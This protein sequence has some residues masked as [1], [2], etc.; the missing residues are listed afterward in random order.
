[1]TSLSARHRPDPRRAIRYCCLLTTAALAPATLWAQDSTGAALLAP[2]P[3]VDPAWVEQTVE[4]WFAETVR[5]TRGE[6]G[7][8]IADQSG[9]LLWGQNPD[10]P[11]VPASTLKVFTTGFARSVLG[12]NARR[13]TRV[14][15][16]G[17]VD[18]VSGQWLGSWGLELNGDPS[19]DVA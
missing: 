2:A 19:L 3:A 11:M 8:A 13:P 9:R 1:M 14:I 7:I 18:P 10:T 6:W 4:P 16:T 12:G 17:T 15:G 5:R